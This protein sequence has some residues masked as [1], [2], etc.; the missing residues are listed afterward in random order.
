MPML[1]F[2]CFRYMFQCVEDLRGD[3][4]LA[5]K[6]I[7]TEL[8]NIQYT[9]LFKLNIESLK[10]SNIDNATAIFIIEFSNPMIDLTL[11]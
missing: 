6:T 9:I 10:I 8:S 3:S 7:Y 11:L 1:S 5:R 4:E 2:L